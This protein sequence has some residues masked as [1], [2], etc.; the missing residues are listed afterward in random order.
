MM[1]YRL[2]PNLVQLCLLFIHINSSRHAPIMRIYTRKFL[3]KIANI[4][5]EHM[6]K[7]ASVKESGIG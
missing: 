1:E 4:G 6:S 5:Q 7:I 3:T 2:K